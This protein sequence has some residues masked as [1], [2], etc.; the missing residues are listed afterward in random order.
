MKGD[1]DT[2]R[3]LFEGKRSTDDVVDYDLV[4][5]LRYYVSNAV[6]KNLLQQH[7]QRQWLSECSEQN[8]LQV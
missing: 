4:A 2:M 8:M 1:I 5:F 6:C 7:L 3:L